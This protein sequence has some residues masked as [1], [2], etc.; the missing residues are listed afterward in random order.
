MVLNNYTEAD[1][2]TINEHFHQIFKLFIANKEV[3]E[4]GTPHLQAYGELKNPTS[5]TGLQSK[6][7]QHQQPRWHVEVAKA[8]LNANVRYIKK[9]K[10]ALDIQIGQLKDTQRSQRVPNASKLQPVIELVRQGT[11]IKTIALEH[12]D[13]YVRSSTGIEK[14]IHHFTNPRSHLTIGYWLWGP[15]GSGKS[16][17]AFKHFPDAY[18]KDPETDWWDGYHGQE[19]VIVDDYRPSKSLSFAKILRLVDRYPLMVQVKCAFAQFVSKRIIFT[20][21]LP[22]LDTFSRCD[23]LKEEELNQLERRMPHQL[24]FHPGLISDHLSP[25][26]LEAN[27][28]QGDA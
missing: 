27:S 21:P 16:R 5:I 12:P 4:S 22:L 13:I 26:V 15:T 19:T 6:L 28:H 23:W 7:I 3:G 24:H 14:L 1:I 10:S 2:V 17:W 11:T 8:D 20:S 18:Y 9:T 25:Q